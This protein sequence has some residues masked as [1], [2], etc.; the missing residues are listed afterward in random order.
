MSPS[1]MLGPRA[2]VHMFK[3]T[4]GLIL[5]EVKYKEADRIL[6]V[7]T[8]DM[9]KITVK[10]RGALRKGSKLSAA[11]QSLVFSE[12]TMFENKGKWSVNEGSTIEEFKGLRLDI[13]ALSLASYIAECTEALATEEQ[14][15]PEL[16]RLALNCLYALSYELY[17]QEH[18]KAAFELRLMGISGYEPEL[19][20]CAVCG[21]ELL[22]GGFFVPS[23]GCM[24]CRE[25][26]DK[27]PAPKLKV[28]RGALEA[29]RYIISSESKKLMSFSVSKDSEKE[30]YRAA[31]E[32][33]LTETER[34]FSTLDYWK[35]VK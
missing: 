33:L 9:G 4:K 8:E 26:M 16:L 13:S 15:E 5:R 6:T 28:G 18:I 29:M 30:L 3:T 12:L 34:K 10:A 1:A 17:S 23:Q 21:D 19:S 22:D 20:R 31:E 27:V 7:L 11:T 25:C 24:L 14:P 35:K 2:D 32:Y